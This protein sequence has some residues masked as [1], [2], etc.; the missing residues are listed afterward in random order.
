MAV[1]EQ[2]PQVNGV[3]I[4]NKKSTTPGAVPTLATSQDL[5]LLSIND[6]YEAELYFNAPDKKVYTILDNTVIDLTG[7]GGG[8]APVENTAYLDL[9]TS[10]TALVSGTAYVLKNSAAGALTVSLPNPS[11]NADFVRVRILDSTSNIKIN[12]GFYQIVSLAGNTGNVLTLVNNES[13]LLKYNSDLQKWIQ[14]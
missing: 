10:G 3:R 8:G 5:N 2:K 13:A 12:A 4:I 9:T 6:I 11:T 1:I 7:S 14:F